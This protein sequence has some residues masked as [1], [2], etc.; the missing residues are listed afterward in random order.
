MPF[1]RAV[2]PYERAEMTSV[3]MTF[4]HGSNLAAPGIFA[5]VLVWFALPTVFCLSGA[6][7]LA[8]AGLWFAPSAGQSRCKGGWFPHPTTE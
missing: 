6:S 1:L 7:L 5:A 4:R 2:H 8:M 3:F